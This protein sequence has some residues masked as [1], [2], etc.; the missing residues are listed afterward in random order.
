[1]ERETQS[2]LREREALPFHSE[3]HYDMGL[4]KRGI[5]SII[6]NIQT[7]FHKLSRP[8]RTLTP[9]NK[10]V[11]LLR[12]ETE[13]AVCAQQA[14]IVSKKICR[15]KAHPSASPVYA[16]AV[17]SPRKRSRPDACILLVKNITEDTMRSASI[18]PPCPTPPTPPKKC[19]VKFK[20]NAILS[21]TNCKY[22]ITPEQNAARSKDSTIH[23]LF[24]RSIS[25]VFSGR[26]TRP[27]VAEQ[28]ANR[29][30][31]ASSPSYPQR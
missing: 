16:S 27:L 28:H 8:G 13:L 11:N 22:S 4:S 17:F 14:R 15:Q 31:T 21:S 26:G 9:A 24:A 18:P 7:M 1:M 30:S 3:C 23:I 29:L 2:L 20:E 10:A 12:R 6:G 5:L 19:R 25:P